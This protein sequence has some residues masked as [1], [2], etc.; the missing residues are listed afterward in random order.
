MCNKVYL[1]DRNLGTVNVSF[2]IS[3]TIIL[4]AFLVASGSKNINLKK[5]KYVRRNR[6][7]WEIQH[8]K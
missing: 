3:C 8:L 7:L 6:L 2:P 1:F 4:M 5:K